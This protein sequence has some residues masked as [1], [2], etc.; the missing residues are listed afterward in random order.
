MVERIILSEN[1]EN[2]E[3]WRMLKFFIAVILILLPSMALPAQAEEVLVVERGVEGLVAVP[4]RI[5]NDTD[6]PV[7]CAA[8]IAHWYS[9][10][11]GTAAPH[12]RLEASLWSKPAS[13]EVF[14]LNATQ[15]RMPVQRLWCGYV[16]EDVSTRSEI[17]LARRAGAPEPAIDL[18]CGRDGGTTALACRPGAQ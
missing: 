2:S 14:L 8:A 3:F 4:F 10:Q 11:I 15:D 5:A 13:G 12:G 16:G 9:A 18:V 7:A 1:D 6:R 17:A